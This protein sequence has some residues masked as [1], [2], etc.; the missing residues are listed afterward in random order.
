LHR[1]TIG[2]RMAAKL[3]D[4]KAKLRVRMHLRLSGTVKWLQ[5]VVRGYFQYHAVPGNL[6]R[7]ARFRWEVAH[8]WYRTLRRRS[9]RSRL[10]REGFHIRVGP[11]L[12]V[13]QVLHPYPDVRFD[14]KHPNIR[15]RN[16]AR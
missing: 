6:Q 3:K 5:Q 13:V 8:L 10:T 4:I 16:R 12:P 1:K 11:L 9:Q 7:M 2:K 15:D 14:V